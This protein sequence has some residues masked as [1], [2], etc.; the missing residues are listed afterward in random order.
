MCTRIYCIVLHP[1]TTIPQTCATLKGW[2]RCENYS[3]V[4]MNK[5]RVDLKIQIYLEAAGANVSLP[6]LLL[7][8]Q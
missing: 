3:A 6:I 4:R 7:R 1:Y 2:I 5:A 8:G